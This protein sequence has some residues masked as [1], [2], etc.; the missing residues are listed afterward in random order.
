METL[1]VSSGCRSTNASHVRRR[2]GLADAVRHIN[3]EKI[4]RRN[5]AIH[6]F[7]ADMVGVHMIRLLPAERLHSGIRLGP[8]AGRLGAD[9]RVFAVG[10]VPDGNEFCAEFSRLNAGLQLRP[11]LMSKPVAHA[12]G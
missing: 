11:A 12:K 5:K 1:P 4:R 10:F 6:R 8:Q 2:G 7:E 3:R 9:E